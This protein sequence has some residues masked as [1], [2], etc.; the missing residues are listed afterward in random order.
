MKRKEYNKIILGKCTRLLQSKDQNKIYEGV[1][2]AAYLVEQ[3]FKSKLR[4]MNLFLYFDQRNISDGQAMR[5]ATNSLSKDDILRAKTIQASNCIT[6]IC[7]CKN[8][9]QKCK[10][11]IE[12]LFVI[13]NFILHSTD[14]FS[15]DENSFAD[16]AVSALRACEKY[17][18]KNIGISSSE[19]NPLTSDEFEKLQRNKHDKRISD[20]K[21]TLTEHKNIF[22]KL[23]QLEID[24]RINNNLPETD[25]SLWVEETVE[26]PACEQESFDKI[27][28]VDFDW[29]PDGIL[30]NGGY[31]YQCRV[32]ELYLSE[33]EY[34]MASN[35]K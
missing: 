8:K 14:D 23:Q 32:C 7:K 26:C 30:A 1:V 34:E 24:N 35:F 19:F 22:K 3:S 31:Y 29:N 28:A 4:G 12:E 27:G 15:Y 25:S 18:T 33:Y 5:I 2:L 13:R 16:T 9:L 20:L 21:M 11:N 6:R 10:A 17:I